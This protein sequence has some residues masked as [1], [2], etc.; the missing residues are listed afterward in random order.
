MVEDHVL[1]R[2]GWYPET[3]RALRNLETSTA[4]DRLLYL[5]M[6]YTE[7]LLGWNSEEW[8]RYL[9][10]S[11]ANFLIVLSILLASEHGPNRSVSIDFYPS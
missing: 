11:V 2:A 7:G 4:K 10:W 6:F 3:Q 8:V 9:G 1:A 5:R